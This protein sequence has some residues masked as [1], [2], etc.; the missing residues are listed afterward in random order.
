MK[1][2]FDELVKPIGFVFASMAV[3][4][5]FFGFFGGVAGL[6]FALIMTLGL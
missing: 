3:G 5:L 4:F 2:F 6:I 1:L